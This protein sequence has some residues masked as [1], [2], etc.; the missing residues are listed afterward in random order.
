M[1]TENELDVE[2]QTEP[3]IRGLTRSA[4]VSSS[5]PPSASPTLAGTIVDSITDDP[6]SAGTH[7]GPNLSLDPESAHILPVPAVCALL[8]SDLEYVFAFFAAFSSLSIG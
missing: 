7:P 5:I 8:N 4:S 2:G 6:A 1:G 3:P